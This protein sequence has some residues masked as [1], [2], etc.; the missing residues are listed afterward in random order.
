MKQHHM[1]GS[2]RRSIH[3]TLNPSGEVD[4]DFRISGRQNASG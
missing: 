3:Q 4:P 1:G 2:M